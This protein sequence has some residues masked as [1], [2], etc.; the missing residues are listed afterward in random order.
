[1]TSETWLLG[2][3]VAMAGASARGV[4]V[5]SARGVG[6]TSRGREGAGEETAALGGVT[7]GAGSFGAGSLFTG[8]GVF[9]GGGGVG[10]P[11]SPEEDRGEVTSS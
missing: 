7:L 6:V 8:S 2:G 1:M 5:A 4:G 10:T 3:G 11:L 9:D